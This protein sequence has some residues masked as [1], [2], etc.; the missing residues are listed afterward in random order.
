MAGSWYSGAAKEIFEAGS[1]KLHS[2][3]AINSAFDFVA[4]GAIDVTNVVNRTFKGEKLFSSKEAKGILEDVYK[5]ADD[6]WNV[7]RIAGS[8]I[9]AS[10][11]ARI[12]TGGGL[13]RDRNGNNNI[14]GIPGI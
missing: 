2:N 3:E 10:G 6:S 11:A 14:I 4:G 5:N 1:K 13:T 8:Y 9:A 7:G 12:A